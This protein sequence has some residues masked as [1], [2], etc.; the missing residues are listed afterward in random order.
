M[1]CNKKVFVLLGLVFIAAGCAAN[2]QFSPGKD[3]AAKEAAWIKD[4]KPIL[5]DNKSWYPTE[6]IENHLDKEMEYIDSFQ[7]VPFYVERRQIRPYDRLYTKFDYH[8]YRMF[9]EKKSYDFNRN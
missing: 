9:L 1:S 3:Y 7:K 5:Y 6:F 8:K 2:S 4:G